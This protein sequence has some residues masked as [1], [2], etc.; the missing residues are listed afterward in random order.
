VIQLFLGF[1]VFGFG[2]RASGGVSGAFLGGR[3]LPGTLRIFS[4]TS[5]EYIAVGPEYPMGLI[6]ALSSL[7]FAALWLIPILSPISFASR[8]LGILIISD[9]ITEKLINI[10][11]VRQ[12][13]IHPVIYF[14]KK[15]KKRR[16]TATFYIDI[17][18]RKCDN[19]I[20]G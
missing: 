19:I 10:E 12:Y 2:S 4:T 17:M 8:P 20:M 14:E 11:E 5:S 7:F 9:Y 3:P 18:S 13:T 16:K 6:P 1:A 15:F